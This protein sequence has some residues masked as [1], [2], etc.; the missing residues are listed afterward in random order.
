MPPMQ[1]DMRV[2]LAD[3]MASLQD[4]RR[5][6]EALAAIF[7]PDSYAASQSFAR[8][9]RAQNAHGWVYGSVRDADGECVALLRPIDISN[10]RQS[11]HLCYVWNGERISQVYEKGQLRSV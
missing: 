11:Q 9:A 3:V 7:D 6:R 1:L 5:M 4:L 8:R 2:Y 10:C